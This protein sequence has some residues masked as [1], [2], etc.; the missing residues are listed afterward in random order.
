MKSFMKI[1]VFPILIVALIGCTNSETNQ[2]DP[3]DLKRVDVLITEE[4][5]GDTTTIMEAEKL[6]ALKEVFANIVWQENV[7]AQMARKE[8]V[9]ATLFFKTEQNSPERLVEYF[10]WFNE[11]DVS[12]TIIDREHHSY[13]T[14]PTEDTKILKDIL[15]NN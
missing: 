7:K 5:I 15:L 6:K 14:L 1:F 13:G 2:F 3:N 4:N 11:N 12:T 10:I 8:D 9:K